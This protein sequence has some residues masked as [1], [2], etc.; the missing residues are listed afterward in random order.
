MD[1]GSVCK[2]GGNDRLWHLRGQEGNKRSGRRMIGKN[3]EVHGGLSE[4]DELVRS[5]FYPK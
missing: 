3:V 2:A 4:D 5:G 1:Q